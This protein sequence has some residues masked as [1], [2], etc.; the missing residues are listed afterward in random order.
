MGI[1]KILSVRNSVVDPYT[2]QI[3]REKS[4]LNASKICKI[5]RNLKF[6][7]KKSDNFKPDSIEVSIS[8]RFH[9]DLH[10]PPF[11]KIQVTQLSFHPD[12]SNDLLTMNDMPFKSGDTLLVEEDK[13][14]AA[15]APT[16]PTPKPQNDNLNS[17]WNAQLGQVML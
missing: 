1:G 11:W 2:V 14:A 9:A 13:T 17:L 8:S 7:R 5:H 15:A 12:V 16:P 6:K 10:H 3:M 4:T